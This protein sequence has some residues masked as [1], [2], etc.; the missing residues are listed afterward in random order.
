M[1]EMTIKVEKREET[2]KNANR[3]LRATGVLPAVV[4]GDKKDSVAISIDRQRLLKLL[5]EGGGENA[6][7]LLELAGTKSSRHAMIRDLQVDPISRRIVHIDFQRIDLKNKV[8]V[9]V[10][11]ELLGEA[12]GVKD[13]GGVL[14]FILRELEVECLPND[15]PQSVSIDVSPLHIGQHVEA[16]EIALPDSVELME[17]PDRVIVAVSH[18]RVEAEVEEL[19]EGEEGEEDLLLEATSDEPE[20]IGK[21]KTEEEEPTE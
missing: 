14:D 21:G 4:Y 8:K 5:K 7:F 3:R 15:I 12:L 20:V 11:I 10:A 2:G 13:E 16:K 1:S 17:E 9:Q 19:A 6:V 18:S